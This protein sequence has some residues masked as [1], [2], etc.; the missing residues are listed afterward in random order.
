MEV[1]VTSPKNQFLSGKKKSMG[2]DNRANFSTLLC[3]ESPPEVRT[4]DAVK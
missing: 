2:G 1:S 4:T 3:N